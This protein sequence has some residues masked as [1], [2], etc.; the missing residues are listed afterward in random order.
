MEAHF[1]CT[2]ELQIWF[3]DSLDDMEPN[4]GVVKFSIVL[5]FCLNKRSKQLTIH[6]DYF[7]NNLDYI[8][9]LF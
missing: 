8:S 9:G 6:F 3:V 4:P 7:W 1:L 2:Q 5:L